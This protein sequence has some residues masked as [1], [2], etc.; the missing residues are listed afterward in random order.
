MKVS[1]AGMAV[2]IFI[3]FFSL[4]VLPI[5]F[6]SIIQYY[7]DSGYEFKAIDENTPEEFHFLK[8]K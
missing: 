3:L 8:H 7:K 4:I 5:Y 1:I 6:M 2:Q